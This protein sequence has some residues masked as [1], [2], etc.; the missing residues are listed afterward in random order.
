ML[1]GLGIPR[2][3]IPFPELHFFFL[4]QNLENLETRIVLT[5]SESDLN[6]KYPRDNLSIFR[7]QAVDIDTCPVNKKYL[8][9]YGA[10]TKGDKPAPSEAADLG[11][12]FPWQSAPVET[13]AC[14]SQPQH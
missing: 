13:Q 9:N 2:N 4:F 1:L 8:Q 7:S 12:P 6:F 11:K 5:K 14:L 10:F 3:L